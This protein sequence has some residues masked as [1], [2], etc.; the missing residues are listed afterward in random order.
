MVQSKIEAMLSSL[1]VLYVED[2]AEIREL[3]SALLEDEGLTVVGCASAEAAETEF[4][5]QHFHVL[6][7]DVSLP[8]MQGTELAKRL[9]HANKNLWVV[10]CS[11]YPM[12]QGLAAWGLRARC[13]PKPFEPEELSA[14]LQEIRASQT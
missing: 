10:F 9:H 11:G 7:T 14:L 3:V 2:N 4:A 5:A 13:L 8:S 1:N 6:I 12:Q